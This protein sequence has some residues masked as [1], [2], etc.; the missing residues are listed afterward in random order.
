MAKADPA[1]YASIPGWS[2]SIENALAE[3]TA[4][5]YAS[6][7]KY[8]YYCCMAITCA[9]IIACLSMKDYDVYMT[10]HVPRQVYNKQERAV[11]T[12]AEEHLELGKLKGIAE[13]RA[14]VAPAESGAKRN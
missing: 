10:K 2:Q 8:V 4:T 3:S 13:E 9:A 12:G 6:A 7:F 11:I 14:E 1:A 5:A